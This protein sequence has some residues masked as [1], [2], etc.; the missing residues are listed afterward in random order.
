MS[1]DNLHQ[2]LAIAFGLGY[3]FARSQI[4]ESERNNQGLPEA[5]LE[6]APQAFLDLVR[7]ILDSGHPRNSPNTSSAGTQTNISITRPAQR[8]PQPLGPLIPVTHRDSR[9]FFAVVGAPIEESERRSFFR[10]RPYI[11]S[12]R[13]LYQREIDTIGNDSNFVLTPLS[14]TE[15]V[16]TSIRPPRVTT[17]QETPAPPPYSPRSNETVVRTRQGLNIIPSHSESPVP[18][19]SPPTCSW[20]NRPCE[21]PCDHCAFH[22]TRRCRQAH[23]RTIQ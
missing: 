21:L 22:H 7:P 19:G 8:T 13:D 3:Q 9:I 15:P 2:Q 12:H 20:C 5:N 4:E 18:L 1:S 10:N 17:S 11:L 23:R 6:N 14:E 16:S